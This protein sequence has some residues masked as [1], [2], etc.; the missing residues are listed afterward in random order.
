MDKAA[1]EVSRRGGRKCG[2]GE[3]SVQRQ[4]CKKSLLLAKSTCMFI[5]YKH[6]VQFHFHEGLRLNNESPKDFKT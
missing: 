5:N 1:C 4:F 2:E 3:L 6:T